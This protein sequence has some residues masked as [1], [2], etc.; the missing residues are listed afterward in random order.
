VVRRGDRLVYCAG[1]LAQLYEEM[2]GSVKYFGKPYAPV[3]EIA[4]QR[5]RE[6]GRGRKPLIVGDGIETDIMG[7][8]TMGWDAL[9][10]AGGVHGVELGRLPGDEGAKRLALLFEEHAVTARYSIPNLRW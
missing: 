9:F 8:N 4:L 6:R 1:A 2:G 7:A 5:A 10:V 3:F